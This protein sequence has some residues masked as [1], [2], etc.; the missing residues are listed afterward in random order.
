MGARGY[1]LFDTPIGRCGIAWGERGV[2]AVQLPGARDADTRARLL[3]RAPDAQE[4]LPPTPAAQAIRAINALLSG[5][6]ADLSGI[7]LD[8]DGVPPFYRRVYEVAR[9]IGPG[10]TL[11][12]GQV[13]ARLLAPGSAR[14]V[15]QALGRNPFPVI[16]PCHRVLAAGGKM[17]GFSA[18]GG[19]ATKLRMLTIEAA[20]AARDGA[21]QTKPTLA[22]DPLAAV[23]HLR[24]ADARLARVIEAVGPCRMRIRPAHST[25]LALTESIVYQQLNGRAAATIFARLCA[26]FPNAHAGFTPEQMLRVSDD[27]LRGAGL[28]RSKL[29]SLRDLAQR[30]AAGELPTLAALREMEDE[31]IVERLSQVRGIG[32]WTVE[33]LLMFRLGRPDVLPLDDFGVRK[34]LAVTLGRRELPPRDALQKRGERWRPYRSVASWYMWRAAEL[35]RLAQ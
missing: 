7:V 25:F 1:T 28:S 11:S 13:A 23:T 34:G 8:M 29:L 21:G 10:E 26:L 16:V 31:A 19:I 2:L 6:P 33:M 12:Y 27:R 17:G 30:A 15:G 3:E 22:F 18:N 9:G 35:G 4:T 14:A 24:D 20:A 5:E 32:R